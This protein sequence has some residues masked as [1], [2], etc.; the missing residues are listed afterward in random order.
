MA[1]G[2]LKGIRQPSFSTFSR[3]WG[4]FTSGAQAEAEIKDKHVNKSTLIASALFFFIKL[5][6]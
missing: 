3:C 1:A 6:L 2:P 5:L 4:G